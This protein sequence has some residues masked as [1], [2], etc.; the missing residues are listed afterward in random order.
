MQVRCH[1][2]GTQA[3]LQGLTHFTMAHVVDWL[4][5]QVTC[6]RLPTKTP[7]ACHACPE[8]IPAGELV[9]GKQALVLTGARNNLTLQVTAS[10]AALCLASVSTCAKFALPIYIFATGLST[11]I[12]EDNECMLMERIVCETLG[13]I[14]CLLKSVTLTW[15]LS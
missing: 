7:V 11:D 14:R 9:S 15:T 12:E 4:W 3:Q 10:L 13:T 6:P 1:R 8:L 5:S 2:V